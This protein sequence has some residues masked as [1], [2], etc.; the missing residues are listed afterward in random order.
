MASVVETAP[1][2]LD[3]G[4]V[5]LAAASSGLVARRL[6]FPAIVGYLLTGLFVSPFTPGFVAD[7]NQLA[8][9]ADIGVVLLLFEVGIEI[10]LGRIRKEQGALLWAA[11]L[12]V[13]VGIALG[14]PI[15]VALGF[16]LLGALLLTLSLALSSSVVIV[17][18]TRSRR[19]TTNVETEE[20]LLGWSVLQDITGVAAAAIVLTFFGNTS[21]SLAVSLGGLGAFV[22]LAFFSAKAIPYLLRLVRWESD[23]FLIFSVAI[24]LSLAALGT[25]LFDIPMALASFVAG[26]S[27]NQSK[28]TDE[29]RKAVLPFRDLFQVLFFVVIGSLVDPE[30]VLQAI[31]FALLLILLMVALKIIPAFLF[32]KF[33][34]LP[35][36]NFQLA[37]GLGQIGEFAFILG[38]L[39]LTAGAIEKVDFTSI[40][41]ALIASIIASTIIVRFAGKR[42]LKRG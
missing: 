37:V 24:G 7:S 15:F 9:L 1:L 28:D 29:I 26:L 42:T 8:L 25:V 21:K 20:A 35:V 41:I 34:K 14:T 19:R 13:L 38:S 10:D 6:G 4:V 2:V 12:Q 27:I 31:P 36:N 18:I 33:G 5:L 17:N 11:P 40:L 39:A 3:V 23:L 22:L 30:L 32:A 16:P